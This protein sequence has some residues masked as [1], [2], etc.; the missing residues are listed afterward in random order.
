MNGHTD[1][2][3]K[4]AAHGCGIAFAFLVI[5]TIVL[6]FAQCGNEMLK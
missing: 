2:Q 3:I 1:R 5:L 6:S 4:D